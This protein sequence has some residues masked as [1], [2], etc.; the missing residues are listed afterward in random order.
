MF[1]MR[2]NEGLF[3]DAGVP[4]EVAIVQSRFEQYLKKG[5]IACRI[6]KDG[7]RGVQIV[8]F[9][10]KAEEIILLSMLEGG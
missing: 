8:E 7:N 3:W 4:E 9:D 10:P 6:E 2:I 1:Y 5:Y